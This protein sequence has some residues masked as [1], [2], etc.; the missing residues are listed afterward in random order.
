MSN[1]TYTPK[2][3]NRRNTQYVNLRVSTIRKASSRNMFTNIPLRCKHCQGEN[4]AWEYCMLVY[5]M[6][7]VVISVAA[8]SSTTMM[9]ETRCFPSL[10]R[11]PVSGL[12]HESE[13]TTFAACSSAEQESD[14]MSTWSL[15]GSRKVYVPRGVS[16]EGANIRIGLWL[17][18]YSRRNV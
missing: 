5:K 6:V 18:S 4:N 2:F 13:E 10:E 15:A 17:W 8:F 11:A 16:E 12:I 9:S 3:V 7:E 14:S 1:C